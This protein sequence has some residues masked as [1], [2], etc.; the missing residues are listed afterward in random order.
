MKLT[1][2]YYMHQRLKFFCK[3]WPDNGQLRPKR[4]ASNS[5]TTQYCV[6]VSDG[7]HV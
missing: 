1:F 4:V 7:I 2:S 5:I 3:Y 6:V